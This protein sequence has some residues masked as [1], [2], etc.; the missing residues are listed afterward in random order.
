MI[1]TCF[2]VKLLLQFVIVLQAEAFSMSFKNLLASY[3]AKK[4]AEPTVAS[5]AGTT[6]ESIVLNNIRYAGIIHDTVT[7]S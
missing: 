3:A 2:T 6:I 1:S 7:Q 5:G 4:P